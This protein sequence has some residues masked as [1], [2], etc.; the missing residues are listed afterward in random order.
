M[1]AIVAK[2]SLWRNEEDFETESFLNQ[3]SRHLKFTSQPYSRIYF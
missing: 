3:V 1:N 2:Q